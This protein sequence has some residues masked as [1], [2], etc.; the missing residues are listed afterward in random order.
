[1]SRGDKSARVE[2][3]RPALPP[4]T[5]AGGL[6]APCRLRDRLRADR[7]RAERLPLPVNEMPPTRPT[8]AWN[9]T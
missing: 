4:R 6:A 2:E 1:M 7:K 5:R 9:K 8:R 3:N